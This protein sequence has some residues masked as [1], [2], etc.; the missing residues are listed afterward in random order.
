MKTRTFLTC[1]LLLL[2]V[3]LPGTAAAQPLSEDPKILVLEA[4]GR[5]TVVFRTGDR[6]KVR[7]HDRVKVKG[8]I[9]RVEDDTLWIDG[10]AFPLER[11]EWIK[12]ADRNFTTVLGIIFLTLSFGTFGVVTFLFLLSL[13]VGLPATF[14]EIV[15]IYAVAGALAL[16]GVGLLAGGGKKR[17]AK[18]DVQVRTERPALLKPGP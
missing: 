6:V 7:T 4:D 15:W 3:L 5:K 14:S 13:M 10:L 2:A 11:I 17:L 16:A 9:T 1:C 12:R 8:D 18:Y